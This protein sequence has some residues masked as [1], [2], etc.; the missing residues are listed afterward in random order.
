MSQHAGRSRRWR[1]KVV[2]SHGRRHERG[3]FQSRTLAAGIFK[4]R[5]WDC[6]Y[7]SFS[8]RHRR[9]RFRAQG[10]AVLADIIHT[11]DVFEAITGNR[12]YRKPYT[13]EEAV[14]VESDMAR[15]GQV[16][17]AILSQSLIDTGTIDDY[18]KAASLKHSVDLNQPKEAPM[19]TPMGAWEAKTAPKLA[20]SNVVDINKNQGAALSA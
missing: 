17:P 16:N 3:V 19:L 12:S 4:G 18:A 14:K 10:N 5:A 2:E 6:E 13:V 9:R 11:T 7:G 1:K 15:E 20:S 8:S